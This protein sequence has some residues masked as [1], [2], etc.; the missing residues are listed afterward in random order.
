MKVLIASFWLMFT[1]QVF[2]NSNEFFVIKGSVLNEA[3]QPIQSASVSVGDLEVLTNADGIFELKAPRSNTYQ[4]IFSKADFYPSVQTFSH[5]EL[6]NDA[7]EPQNLTSVTLVDKKANRTMLAF[8]GDVMMGRRYLAPYFGDEVLI[9]PKSVKADSKEVVKHIKPYMSLADFAAVNLETQ[10]ASEKP[11]KRAPKSVTFFTQPEVLDSLSWA[12]IDYVSLG[13]NHTYDYLD[14][15]LTST[16]ESLEKSSLAYSGA[17][18][19]EETALEA[20]REVING[21]AFSMLGYVGWTGNSKPKQTANESQ[22]GAAF[23]NMNNIYNT[24]ERER[25]A[26]HIPIIQY[27]GSQEYANEP[28]GV[29]E[30]RL[31]SG[32]DHGA[33]LAIAHH[34]HV[35]QGIELYNSKLIA[36]SM[37]NFIFD[38]N[39]AATQHSFILYVWL[40]G[41]KFHRAEIVPIYVKGYKP[42][43]A[44][45]K[46]RNLVMRRIKELSKQR[47]TFI[48]QAGG[49]GIITA[50]NKQTKST[51]KTL[52]LPVTNNQRVFSLQNMPWSDELS[53]VSTEDRT[54][55]Y[56]LGTDLNNGSDFE[57]FD[58]FESPERTWLFDRSSATLNTFGASGLRSLGIDLG[59]GQTS[60]FGMQNFRRV[61]RASSPVTVKAY[62]NVNQPVKATFYWQ[63][64][65][66]R[67]KLFDAMEKGTKHAFAQA[68]LTPENDKEWQNV[69]VDFNSPRVGYRSY[70][71]L[72]EFETADGKPAKVNIDD[73]SVIQWES[74]FSKNMPVKHLHYGSTQASFVGFNHCNDSNVSVTFN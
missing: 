50:E 7:F 3:E 53:L 32:L 9:H 20:H 34:P 43:P 59:A 44:T 54:L 19:T 6:S 4:L 68:M 47:N 63:G 17:G 2:A 26:K 61:Y 24:I 52:S 48:A 56:R 66:T 12:G 62:F 36:Y 73:F 72:V 38:Q 25:K 8:G 27:H 30:Q 57:S 41:E 35:T 67:Q 31:K 18:H 16:L 23:G 58:T 39:F 42:T 71:V 33:A 74:A 10:L 55:P 49:H 21:T 13:N 11:K 64:R 37:G 5:Y 14:E 28:T 70:R 29:T 22:G 40:D 15:G 1:G 46:H 45:G 60:T 51:T 69:E 65:K